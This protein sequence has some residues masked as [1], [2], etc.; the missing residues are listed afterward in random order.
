[1]TSIYWVKSYDLIS[2]RMRGKYMKHIIL[3]LMLLFNPANSLA[4]KSPNYC[5]DP[6]VNAKW[7]R[8]LQHSPDDDL[9]AK[10]FALRIGLCELVKRKVISLER[11]TDIF[12]AERGDGVNER[13]KE[14]LRNQ[15]RQGSNT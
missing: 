8:M 13:K 14:F 6:E 7:L 5:L 3:V 1:M 12:E 15:K 2:G 10:L 4:G 9:I 11:A